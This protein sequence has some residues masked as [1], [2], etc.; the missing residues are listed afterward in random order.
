MVAALKKEIAHANVSPMLTL[1]FMGTPEFAVPTLEALIQKGHRVSLVVTQPDKPKGRGQK[2]AASPV[3][4]K[5]LELGIPVAQPLSLKTP[6]FHEQIAT[7]KADLM[8]VVAFRI[9]PVTL[10]PLTRLGAV[11]IHGSLLPKYRGAA[12]I[13]WAIAQGETET[14]VT[15]FQLDREI[16]HGKILAQ[17]RASIGAEETAGELFQ[18]L[19]VL[20]R[21]LLLNTLAAWEQ[22]RMQSLDQN[23]DLAT[24][25][26]KLHKEDGKLDWGLSAAV[27]HNRVRAFN[28]YPT[29]YTQ[30]SESGRTLRVHRARVASG[31]NPEPG[32]LSVDADRFPLVGTG[33]GWLKLLEVQWEG[34]PRMSGPDFINGLR[35]AQGMRFV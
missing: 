32:V 4:A 2:L 11:N 23:H 3:K 29:C 8:V 15:I 35:G 18:R 25:A 21:D 12:P 13:Q 9:L 17:A 14:G 6:E 34:K 20:G 10:F 16:D 31:A 30:E 7:Q 5:A 19:S 27:L 24:P 26:P 28:P 1:I 33:D 22:N